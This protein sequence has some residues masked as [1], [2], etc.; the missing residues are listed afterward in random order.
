MR[1]RRGHKDRF[2]ARAWSAA[3]TRPPFYVLR[4]CRW[5]TVRILR[6]FKRRSDRSKVADYVG[7]ASAII[8]PPAILSSGSTGLYASVALLDNVRGESGPDSSIGTEGNHCQCPLSA[9]T[10]S[11][12]CACFVLTTYIQRLV[13]IHLCS[14]CYLAHPSIPLLSNKLQL[15]SRPLLISLL[16]HP[17]QHLPSRRLRNRLHKSHPSPQLL[18]RRRPPRE[19]LDD[20]P[21]KR[22]VPHDSHLRHDVGARHL[23]LSLRVPDPD[24]AGVGD[25]G[26]GEEEALQLGGGDLEA[27][28]RF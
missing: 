10:M 8:N 5:S 16:Q 26:A 19:P 17:P 15:R 21:R 2:I 24:D 6:V 9:R 1:Q 18:M 28:C 23:G 25:I 27:V 14:Y 3:K 20:I 12:I 22:V 4:R 13:D 7:A 11:A